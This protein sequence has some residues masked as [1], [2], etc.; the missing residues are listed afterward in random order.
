MPVMR[1]HPRQTSFH[2]KILAYLAGGGAANTH[3]KRFGIGNFR[4]LTVT[5]S[6]D[7]IVT[8][9]DAVKLATKG[10]GSNQF[11]FTDRATLQACP[12]VLALD[13]ISGKG[14][15]VRLAA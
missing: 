7:R 3:G 1:S 12:D 8:M 13:W 10:H 11:L 15:R 2:Q 6:T 5:T 9:I 14:E 4:V